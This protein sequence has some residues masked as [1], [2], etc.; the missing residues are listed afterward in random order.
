[1]KDIKDNFSNQAQT[2]AGY[3]PGYPDELFSFL[4]GHCQEFDNVWDCATGNGQAAVELAN[5]FQ[6]VYATDI[7]RKQLDNTTLRENI[8]YSVGRAEQTSFTEN[9]FD[10]V[11]VAQAL[12]WFDHNVFFKEVQRVCKPDALFA[13]W[14]YGLIRCNDEVI[15]NIIDQFYY[16]ITGPYWDT[17]RKHVDEH[18][19]SITIPFNEIS[20]PEFHI[21]YQWSYE[22]LSG[23]FNT[24]SSVQ[25]YIKANN[26]NPVA[27]IA[28]ELLQ[29]FN[30]KETIEVTF[31]IFMKAGIVN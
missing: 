7:S 29:S 28:E 2:Y 5:K 13:A 17:E 15:N 1:M 10:L 23:Y 3:R 12:H 31:P 30:A 4:Y 25:H 26:A 11:T 18:Y 8:Y 9:T 21:K 20:C 16:G 6:Q 14:G 22:Q 24:W 19:R 27:L